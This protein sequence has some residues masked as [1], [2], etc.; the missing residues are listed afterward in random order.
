[1]K[2][3]KLFKLIIFSLLLSIQLFPQSISRLKAKKEREKKKREKLKIERVVEDDSESDSLAVSKLVQENAD[4]TEVANVNDTAT[5]SLTIKVDKSPQK[6]KKNKTIN[7]KVSLS[8][9]TIPEKVDVFLD[10]SLIGKTPISGEKILSGDRIFEIRKDGFAPISY[11]LNV[12]P[13][14]SVNLDFFMNPIY[15]VKFKTDEVGL[16][17]ELND[18]HRWTEDAIRMQLEA[19]DHQLRVYKLGEIVDEQIIVAD[20]PL[21]FQYYLKRGVVIKP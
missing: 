13:S 6:I 15:N 10:G 3:N 5:D 19:G 12:N 11:E 21:T 1:M 2:M 16:I 8:I 4:N 17:F 14:K 20:Q 9:N 7:S 18:V